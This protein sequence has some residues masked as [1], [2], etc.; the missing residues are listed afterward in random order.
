MANTATVLVVDDNEIVLEMTR[1]A[2]ENAGYRV[3]T[4]SK[5]SGTVAAVLHERPDVV[6]LDVKMPQF[7]G[8]TI[9]SI[10]TRATPD[11]RC[12]VLLYS[13]CSD[14]V[15]T[16]KVWATGADGFIQKTSNAAELVHKIDEWLAKMG[17]VS[18]P[19]RST[20]AQG[21]VQGSPRFA[22][23]PAPLQSGSFARPARVLFVDSDPHSIPLYEAVIREGN[24]SGECLLSESE[25]RAVLMGP[26]LPDVVVYDPAMKESG[27]QDLFEH[28]LRMDPAWKRRFVLVT[29]RSTVAHGARSRVASVDQVLYKP[30]DMQD[31]RHAIR[32]ASIAARVFSSHPAPAPGRESTPIAPVKIRK[33]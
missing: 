28:A 5:G 10:L 3:V 29:S 32:F 8:D 23:S 11:N 24:V 1:A 6:L 15:L 25:A 13:S 30:V 27:G 20:R 14:D 4:R 21:L 26:H 22:S 7:G 16:Q 12:I 31:L 19:S 2:L 9:A 33:S 18:A 17:R